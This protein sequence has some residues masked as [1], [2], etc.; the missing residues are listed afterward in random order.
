MKR[1]VLFLVL[2]VPFA[3]WAADG[4][5]RYLVREQ[6]NYRSC[7]KFVAAQDA[8]RGGRCR[9]ANGF[10]AWLFGFLTGYS[11]AASGVYDIALGKDRDS[12]D[13]WI[14][15]Y[16]KAHPMKEVSD[17]A[18]R[19]VYTLNPTLIMSTPKEGKQ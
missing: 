6:I 16:C 4:S 10:N 15:G 14:E 8:C 7:G 3:C 9:E 13:L 18:I 11:A 12:I 1:L 2:L 19:L 5:G 17:A